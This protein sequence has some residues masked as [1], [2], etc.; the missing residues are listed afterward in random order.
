MLW[1]IADLLLKLPRDKGFEVMLLGIVGIW[2]CRGKPGL[3]EGSLLV[4]LVHLSLSS[5]RFIP[6]FAIISGACGSS[7]Q[8]EP[9]KD[10]CRQASLKVKNEVW[11]HFRQPFKMESGF[12]A[13]CLRLQSLRWRHYSFLVV[14]GWHK[15]SSEFSPDGFQWTHSGLQSGIK[16]TAGCLITMGGAVI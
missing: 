15:R 13:I 14:R 9:L 5:V 2:S 6:L 11:G 3:F 12:R 4:M 8:P 7:V 16:L 1:Y 10:S